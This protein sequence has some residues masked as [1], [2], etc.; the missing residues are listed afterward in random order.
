MTPSIN[1]PPVRENEDDRVLSWRFDQLCSLGFDDGQ[2]F[3]LA[4]CDLDLHL[5]RT[6]IRQGCPPDLAIEIAL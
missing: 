1:R 5:L 3:V 2:A 4:R 6:L